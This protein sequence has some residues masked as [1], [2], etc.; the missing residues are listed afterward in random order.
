LFYLLFNKK[1]VVERNQVEDCHDDLDGLFSLV[2]RVFVQKQDVLIEGIVDILRA[3]ILRA[4][5]IL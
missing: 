4:H 2:S 3:D 5:L 1:F